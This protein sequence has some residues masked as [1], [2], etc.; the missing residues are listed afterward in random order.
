MAFATIVGA[1][2]IDQDLAEMERSGGI[3]RVNFMIALAYE[4]GGRIGVNIFFALI[5]L[6][7]IIFGIRAYRQARKAKALIESAKLKASSSAEP[8]R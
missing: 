4:M 6:T 5:A 8:L 3:E 1:V 7:C 2:L